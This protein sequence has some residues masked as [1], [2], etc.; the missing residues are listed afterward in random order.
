MRYYD[1]DSGTVYLDG[2]DLRDIDL[3]WLRKQIGYVGQEPV[4]F[5]TSIRY[6]L[7]LAKSDATED[8]MISALNKA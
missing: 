6:N 4:L 8:E 3:G 7:L 2:V 5:A 1:P